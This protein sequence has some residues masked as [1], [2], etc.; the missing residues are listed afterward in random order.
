MVSESYG[1]GWKRGA[2]GDIYAGDWELE[3]MKA[4]SKEA[5]MFNKDKR[6]DIQRKV[7]LIILS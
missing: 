1:R 7:T 3:M 4:V 2:E 6:S 5:H